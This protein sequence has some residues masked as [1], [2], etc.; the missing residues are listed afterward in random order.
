M[1]YQANPVIVDAFKIV[2]FDKKEKDFPEDNSNSTVTLEDGQIITLD[3]VMM[4]RFVPGIGDYYVIQA[5]GYPYLNPKEVFEKKY[6]P[7]AA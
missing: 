3:D 7:I 4:S 1:K 2:A 6:A 5:D